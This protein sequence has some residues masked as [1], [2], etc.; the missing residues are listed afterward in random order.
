MSSILV[1]NPDGIE[2]H[3][4]Q[5]T[6]AGFARPETRRLCSA[7]RRHIPVACTPP[8][9]DAADGDASLSGAAIYPWMPWHPFH[10]VMPFP[11][12]LRA[13]SGAGASCAADSVT[14]PSPPGRGTRRTLAN[15]VEEHRIRPVETTKGV[16]YA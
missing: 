7:C 14:Q 11:Y 4:Q 5:R 2:M 3:R 9:N 8:G 15:H 16:G 10:S 13:S 12:G 1:I 6:Q